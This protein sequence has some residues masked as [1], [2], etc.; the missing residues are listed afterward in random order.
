MCLDCRY[1]LEF[2]GF[3]LEFDSN[4]VQ[5]MVIIINNRFSFQ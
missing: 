1:E 2:D 5:T 4:Q 3:D